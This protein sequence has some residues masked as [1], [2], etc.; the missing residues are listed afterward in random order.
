[1]TGVVEQI[2]NKPLLYDLQLTT[3]HAIKKIK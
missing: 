1:V 3:M 2:L